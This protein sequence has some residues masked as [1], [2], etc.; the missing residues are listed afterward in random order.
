MVT[1]DSPP[2]VHI[3]ALTTL[4]LTVIYD[5]RPALLSVMSIA[6][7]SKSPSGYIF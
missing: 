2:D 1:Y 6:F 4:T 5:L 3:F 7:Y